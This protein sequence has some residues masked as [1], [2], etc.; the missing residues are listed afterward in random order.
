VTHDATAAPGGAGRRAGRAGRAA[1]LLAVAALAGWLVAPGTFWRHIPGEDAL[2]TPA[3]GTWKAPRDYE[4][5]DEEATAKLRA[6]AAEGERAVWDLDDGAVEAAASRARAAFRD[7]RELH[8]ARER[9][10]ATPG[11]ERARFEARLGATVRGDH[12]EALA[13]AGFSE[14][15]E[16]QVVALAAH[17]L[18]GL[19]VE[20]P[21]RLAGARQ[22]VVVRTV[23]A[24]APKDEHVLFDVAIVRDVA[25]ARA[26]VQRDAGALPGRWPPALRDA[27]VG[28]TGAL[29]HPT[30]VLNARETAARRDAAAERVRPV[31]LRLRRGEKI[32]GDGERIE[33]RHLALFRGIEA[34]TRPQDLVLVRLGGALVVALAGA[35]LWRWAR[36]NVRGFTPGDRDALLLAGAFAATLAVAAAGLAIGE[37]LHERLPRVPLEAFQVLVPF[38]AGAMVV[39]AVLPAEV[40]LLFAVAAGTGVGLL[41]GDSL[42]LGVHALLTGITAVGLVAGTRDRAALFR[43]GALVGLAGA[44]LAL[45]GHLLAGGGLADAAWPALAALVA[46]AV[47]V[48]VVTV[49]TLPLVEWAFGYVT[50]LKLLELANLNHPALKDLIVQAPGTWHHSVVMGSLV[51]A[52]AEAIGANPLLAKVCAYYHDVG[53]STNPTWFAENQRGENRHDRTA[54]GMSALAV[55]RHVADGLEIARRWKLPQAVADAIPQHHGTRYVS[56]FR[57]KALQ[58]AEACGRPA[59]VDDALFRYP[60]PKPQSREA[61]LVM[62]ADTCEASARA[63]SEPTQ[64]KLRGLVERRIHEVFAEGQLD[65]CPLTLKDLGL[66][67]GAMARALEAVYHARPEYPADPPAQQPLQLVVKS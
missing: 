47:L 13:A 52:A 2:G 5:L 29:V 19:V 56:F 10:R 62:I 40:A 55:K 3:V 49:G 30:L 58:E 54:P 33:R 35:V 43:A 15:V 45:G 25:A 42:R 37:A 21:A 26:D 61:A 18:A 50:D 1:L 8:G 67:A 63:M 53:K 64:E 27:V 38:A 46:G 7:L 48:P 60:G 39:R 65:E 34:Q 16:A 36:R 9:G 57:A 6:E 24:G 12:V 51:E 32:V 41:G 59:E 20:D 31:L 66:V 28:V 14:E 23:R 22:G 17:A 11:E 4:I 44:A